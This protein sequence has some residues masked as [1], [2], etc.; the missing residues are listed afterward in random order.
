[1]Q[2]STDKVTNYGDR[3]EAARVSRSQKKKL[4][5]GG[6]LQNFKHLLE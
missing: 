5:A 6:K 3:R 4:I 2:E 1:M